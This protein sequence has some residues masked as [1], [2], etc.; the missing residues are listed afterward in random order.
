MT[1]VVRIVAT[2]DAKMETGSGKAMAVPV[3]LCVGDSMLHRRTPDLP[4]QSVAR[5]AMVLG[6]TQS[7]TMARDQTPAIVYVHMRFGS[8]IHLKSAVA[9]Y[10]SGTKALTL[11][12]NV[13]PFR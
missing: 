12:Y 10:R 9:L 7:T 13:L 6:E 2:S 5:I 3:D 8:Y 11:D 4:K 1:F